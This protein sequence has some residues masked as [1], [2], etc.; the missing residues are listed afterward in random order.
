MVS[1]ASASF[2]LWAEAYLFFSQNTNWPTRLTVRSAPGTR[3]VNS[4]LFG[5]AQLKTRTRFATKNREC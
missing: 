1:F 3:P 5:S 2:G 4:P